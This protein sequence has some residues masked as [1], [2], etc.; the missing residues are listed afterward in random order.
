MGIERFEDLITW[1]EARNLEQSIYRLTQRELFRQDRG[2]V[3]Q[4]QEAAVSPMGLVAEAHGRYSSE[5][6]RRLLDIALGS[7][8][9]V[10]SHLN[11]A[12]DRSYIT[13]DD[14]EQPYGQA[15]RV[16]KLINGQVNNLDRQIARRSP[17]SPGPRHR[18]RRT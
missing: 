3:W 7:C 15:D 4:I 10:Q 1:Q 17:E 5:D 12:L 8:R 2:L 14:F 13:K 11:V 18:S 9:E 16:T 6:K